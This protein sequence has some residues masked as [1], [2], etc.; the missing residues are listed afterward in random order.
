MGYGGNVPYL[1]DG[2]LYYDTVVDRRG[3]VQCVFAVVPV[4]PQGG[5][6]RIACTALIPAVR[7]IADKHADAPRAL[8]QDLSITESRLTRLIVVECYCTPSIRVTH[9]YDFYFSL[10][11][12]K[13]SQLRDKSYSHCF[14]YFKLESNVSNVLRTVTKLNKIVCSVVRAG[15][16]RGGEIK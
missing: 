13:I 5:S 6:R 10:I 4:R 16:I 2:T 12:L 7:R 3:C 8:C 11:L 9:R 14:S 15:N 1:S